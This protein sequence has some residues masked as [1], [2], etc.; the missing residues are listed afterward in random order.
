MIML[1]RLYISLNTL[2]LSVID[3]KLTFEAHVEAHQR[4]YFLLNLWTNLPY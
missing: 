3:E 4:M 1:L 2:V